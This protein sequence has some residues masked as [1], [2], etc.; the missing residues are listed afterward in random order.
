VQQYVVG[1]RQ[2]VEW[3]NS[4][5]KQ[6]FGRLRVPLPADP[7]KRNG[8]LTLCCRMYNLRVRLVGF[9]QIRSVFNAS[10]KEKLGDDQQLYDR[11]ADWYGFN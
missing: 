4:A 3:G 5:L 10:L 8:I 6:Q 9:N 2:S 11:V 1:M 7:V